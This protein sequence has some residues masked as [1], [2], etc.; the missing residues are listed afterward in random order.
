MALAFDSSYRQFQQRLQQLQIQVV[1]ASPH[2]LRAAI[3]EIQQMFQLQIVPL[4]ETIEA[5][6]STQLQSIHTEINKQLRL[7]ETD[8][9][10]LQ[11]ARQP[12]TAQQRKQQINHRLDL[13][14][15][16][17]AASLALQPQPDVFSDASAS[18]PESST[19]VPP[20]ESN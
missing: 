9:V 3:A 16:Y 18:T 12:T 2:E 19:K 13:L 11:A 15:Q 6:L 5:S 8:G 10:F 17:C 20:T 4:V 7:L 14:L 1:D